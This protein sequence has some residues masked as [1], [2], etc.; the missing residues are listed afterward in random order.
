[1]VGDEGLHL[2]E[3]DL[4]VDADRLSRQFRQQHR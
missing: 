3:I 4:L 2:R 1:M